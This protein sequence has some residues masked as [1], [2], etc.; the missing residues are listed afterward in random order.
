M[1]DY[2]DPIPP[3]L[4]F[5]GPR[6]PDIKVYGN[7]I[8]AQATLPA[9]LVKN[10]GGNGYTRL[11]LLCRADTSS[12]AMQGLIRAMNIIERYAAEIDGL[13]V[14]WCS[15][16]SNPIPDIDTDTNEPEAWCY[17]KLEHLEA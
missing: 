9:L 17:M 4:R 6:I 16:E 3:V 7:A 2:V 14:I 8:P 15:K 11:Q 5:F 13:S 12:G 1:I 10:A